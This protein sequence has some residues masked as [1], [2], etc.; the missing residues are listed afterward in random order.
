VSD[1]ENARGPAGE[2]GVTG[3]QG[4]AGV[5]GRQGEA[6]ATGSAGEAGVA[7][8]A[9]EVGAVGRR[10]RTGRGL[11]NTQVTVVFAFVVLAFVVLSL[12]TEIQ[13]R[14]I[15]ANAHRIEV[16]FFE[17]CTIR[18]ITAQNQIKLI[19]SAIASEKR[20]PKPDAKRIRDLEQFRPSV[21]NCGTRPK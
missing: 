20:K 1:S 9:G 13:Q 7:G 5:S 6:G 12:R 8:A 14:A 15:S 11:S 4:E 18:N 19:D 17:Q 21:V 2:R 16:L 3:R 10:G